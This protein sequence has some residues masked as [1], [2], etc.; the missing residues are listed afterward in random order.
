MDLSD[1]KSRLDITEIVGK[2]IEIDK[3]LTI[4]PI[5]KVSYGYVGGDGGFQG[6]KNKN[7]DSENRINA[8]GF[9]MT[10]T[11]LGVL[12]VGEKTSYVKIDESYQ[13]DKW[14]NLVKSVVNGL[15][16]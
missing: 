1:L 13:E 16:K 14:I 10:V 15:Q 11:P 9:G 6:K 4:V 5:S 8:N 3:Y 12:M 7:E 2:P